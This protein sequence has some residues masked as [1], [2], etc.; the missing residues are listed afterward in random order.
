MMKKL[1]CTLFLVFIAV[2]TAQAQEEINIQGNGIDIVS[3][4]TTPSKSQ[5]ESMAFWCG[6]NNYKH[7]ANC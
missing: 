5:K 7:S 1:L 2:N 4:D 6:L 3:G